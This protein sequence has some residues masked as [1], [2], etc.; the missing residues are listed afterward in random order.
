MKDNI[1]Q[2][3]MAL[4]GA[5][6]ALLIFVA[7]IALKNARESEMSSDWVNHTHAVILETVAI[8]TALQTAEANLRNYVLSGDERDQAAY[9]EAFSEMIEHLEVAKS[10]TK[11]VQRQH[12]RLMELEALA[13]KRV[14]FARKVVAVQ[15]DEGFE[16]AKKLISSDAADQTLREIKKL[17]I[18]LKDEEAQ[19]LQQRDRE[20]FQAAQSTRWTVYVVAGVNVGLIALI[21]W[22]IR[23][24]LRSRRLAADAMRLANEQ[25]EEKVTA[26][27]E[28]IIKINDT[29]T[30]EN[31]ERKWSQSILER[32]FR[33]FE[34][35][36]HSIGDAIF[37]ISRTGRIIRVN[38]P[39]AKM[40]GMTVNDLIGEQLAS[41][42]QTEQGGD[43]SPFI[44]ALK[45]GR[46][47]VGVHA[48]LKVRGGQPLGVMARAFPV[49]DNDRVVGAVVVCERA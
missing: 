44:T 8:E 29:L 21:F 45:E 43:V 13:G 18:K 48:T 17:V 35:I 23:L 19:L 41:V 36:L 46:D 40:S 24:D 15:K 47:L 26:R 14:E 27:T 33:H 6:A 16:A 9:R 32:Q 49:R 22:L 4:F 11:G 7:V 31:L 39:A 42:V 20:N 38:P 37:V 2:R 5:V 30:L 28:E 3:M 12:E 10:M 1:E 34:Q 25:L